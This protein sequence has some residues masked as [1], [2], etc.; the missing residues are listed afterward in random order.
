MRDARAALISVEIPGLRRFARGLLRGDRDRADDLLQ[1]G[2]ERALAHWHDR[3][4]QGNLRGWLYTI[5]YNRFASGEQ[6]RRRRGAALHLTD[7]GDAELPGVDGGQDAA[8][9]YRDFLR[10]FREL[11][12]KQRAVIYLIGVEGLSYQEVARLLDLPIGTVMSR[13]SRARERLRRHMDGDDRPRGATAVAGR[14]AGAAGR[15]GGRAAAE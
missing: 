1:D 9:R 2:L 15:T 13:R 12:E 4:P 14:A 6:L 11:P 3:R 10:G 8:L 5:V 7:A